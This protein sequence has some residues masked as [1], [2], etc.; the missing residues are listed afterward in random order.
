MTVV[1]AWPQA[2]AANRK[3]KTK[4]SLRII[5]RLPLLSVRIQ[6][7]PAPCDVLLLLWGR[8][9]G[10]GCRVGEPPP[11]LLGNHRSCPAVRLCPPAVPWSGSRPVW[12]IHFP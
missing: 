10:R 7:L 9:P 12:L 8:R 11:G 5:G 6:L 1:S 4:P 2:A 3:R